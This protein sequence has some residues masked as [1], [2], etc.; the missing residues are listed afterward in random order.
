MRT[1]KIDIPAQSYSVPV[2]WQEEEPLDRDSLYDFWI[3]EV[4]SNPEFTWKMVDE[5]GK[6]VTS[7]YKGFGDDDDD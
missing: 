3:H 7:E 4:V 5:D 2:E 1:L 6:D